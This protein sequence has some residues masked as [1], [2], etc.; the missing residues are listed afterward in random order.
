MRRFPL[1]LQPSARP[2]A[3]R[4]E[5]TLSIPI[6]PCYC[7]EP[8]PILQAGE[9]PSQTRRWIQ[10]YHVCQPVKRSQQALLSSTRLPPACPSIHQRLCGSVSRCLS[11]FRCVVSFLSG[12]CFSRHITKVTVLLLGGPEICIFFFSTLVCYAN[13][14]VFA[15]DG[16]NL[17]VHTGSL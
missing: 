9:W 2:F 5:P 10:A 3:S 13:S 17:C 1:G 4:F 15:S 7:K 8:N 14:V 6:Q 16:E 11:L 12:L